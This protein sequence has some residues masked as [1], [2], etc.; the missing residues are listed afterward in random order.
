MP[1]YKTSTS[2]LDRKEPVELV[3]EIPSFAGGENTIGE[4]QELKS[5]E[6]RIIE[7]WDAVSVGGME[8]TKGFTKKN[9]GTGTYTTGL[10]DLLVHHFEGTSTRNYVV[11]EGDLAYLNG[12]NITQTDASAFTSGTLCHA[13]SAG[14]K[15]WI[16]N[17]TDNLKYTTIAGSI[18]APTTTPSSARD[19]IYYHKSRLVAEGGGVTVYGSKAGSGNWAGAG[20]WSASGDAWNI[21]LPDLTKGCAPGFP[22]PNEITVF[23]EFGAYILS[24]FP[25]VAF[26]PVL[27][28]YGC[29]APYSIA[30]GPQGL[31]FVAKYPTLGVILWDG[32]NYI[33]LTINEDWIS[34]VDLTKRCFGIFSDNKYRIFYNET[35]SGVTYPNVMRVYDT[36]FGR[37][38]KRPINSSVG[39]NFGYP[40]LLTKSSNE[41]YVGSSRVAK[42]YQLEDTSNADNTYAT[43]A[44]YQ[45]KDFTSLDFR[46]IGG[47]Q[48]PIDEVRL[49]LLKA[50]VSYYG[51]TGSFTLL[52]SSDR[53]L[54]SG[55]QTYQMTAYG[56]LLNSSFTVNTSYLSTPPPTKTVT[57]SFTNNAIGRRFSFQLLNSATGD[58]PKIK[59]IKIFAVAYEE[60]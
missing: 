53:G 15:L 9:D 41:L 57:R 1:L 46:T 45:T 2:I 20:G 59:K 31:F 30:L 8:R 36:R 3:L 27:G 42:V 21:D 35:G 25:N 55:S 5:N 47:S 39:D 10:I 26:R 51:S 37:W 22:S 40:A 58:R 28:S 23:T 11:T 54:H 60:N 43:Q 32:V 34:K 49:K 50:T 7:N 52:W 19:R 17:S 29:S 56:S 16:T 48:F 18:A 4:D 12:S 44:N 24:N 33:N 6:A 38:M 13:V 14:S